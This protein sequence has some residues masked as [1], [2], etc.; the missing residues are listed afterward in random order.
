M[1]PSSSRAK[2][3]HLAAGAPASDAVN[4]GAS[5]PPA[6]PTL[7]RRG[8]AP[9]TA[10]ALITALAALVLATAHGSERFAGL[11]PCELCLRQRVPYWTA[12]AIGLAGLGAAHLP[13]GLA[14][15]LRSGLVRAAHAGLAVTFLV[16]A[17]LAVQH[18]GVEEGLW[19]S[20][21]GG[22]AGAS[23][24]DLLGGLGDKPIVPCDKKQPFLF[25]LTMAP[26]NFLASVALAAFASAA[27]ALDLRGKKRP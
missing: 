21:C 9:A 10:L 2:P 24:D 6:L 25:G 3:S 12:I 11:V 4:G 5:P 16:S 14:P 22:A 19:R 7:M 15:R 17:G 8:L 20:S 23:I 1:D 13:L 27:L 26:Y 18:I